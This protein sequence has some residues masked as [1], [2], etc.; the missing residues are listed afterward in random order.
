MIGRPAG[1]VSRFLTAGTLWLLAFAA[2]AHAAD[3][4]PPTPLTLFDGRTL[5]LRSLA[6]RVI[7]IRFAAS[8]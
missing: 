6:G 4:L 8:W 7:V 3:V 2:S 5:Q 1:R